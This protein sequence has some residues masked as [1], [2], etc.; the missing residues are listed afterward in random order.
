[1]NERPKIE[2]GRTN[3][4][5]ILEI[6]GWASLIFMWALTILKYTSLPESIPTHF[7]VSGK[8]D[9]YGS[10]STILFLPVLSTILF[11]GMTI[12]NKYPH[13]FNYPVPITKE[14]AE[15]QYRNATR[16]IRYIKLILVVT[17]LSIEYMTI[18]TATGNSS[19]L[20]TW[21][22]PVMLVLVFA[23]IAIFIYNA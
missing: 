16:L 8:V 21:F 13:I 19:G 7:D 22:L 9:S 14:N 11:A 3:T 2:I 15:R 12:L 6:L 1:M 10:R 23:P 20:A 18:Q 4:D 5:D 17:F